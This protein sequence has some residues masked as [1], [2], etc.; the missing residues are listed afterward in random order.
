MPQ[1][2]SGL[3]LLEVII[4]LA[5]MAGIMIYA[6]PTATDSKDYITKINIVAGDVKNAFDTA[7]LTGKPYRLVFDFDRNA[8]WLET[9]EELDFR[10]R[11][12]PD[13]R[14]LNPEQQKEADLAFDAEFEEYI[15]LAGK[16]VENPD[17]GDLI[18]P[19][20]PVVQAKSKLRGPAWYEVQSMEW[21]RRQIGPDLIVDRFQTEHH[22]EEVRPL[23]D[24]AEGQVGFIYF[25]PTGYVEKAY[26]SLRP[27]YGESEID[28]D[29]EPFTLE[30]MPYEGVALLRDGAIEFKFEEKDD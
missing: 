25:F 26:I 3:T 10:I 17:T 19:A 14:D 20:S 27:L 30:V 21:D 16:E 6:L 13:G 7:V 28:E 8:Y 15:E 2:T 29:D 9:T 24:D 4:V 5:L 11:Q 22:E 18:K 12:T 23:E 1:R